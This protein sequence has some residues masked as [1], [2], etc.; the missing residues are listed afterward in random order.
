MASGNDVA[1]MIREIASRELWGACVHE[2][3]HTTVACVLGKFARAHVWRNESG[4]PDEKAWLGQ[5]RCHGDLGE[6]GPVI[7]LAGVVAEIV[8]IDYPK[9]GYSFADAEQEAADIR[10]R[11]P[12]KRWARTR[13]AMTVWCAWVEITITDEK[14]FDMSASDLK[15]M[16]DVWWKHVRKTVRLVMKHTDEILLEAKWLQEKVLREATDTTDDGL[17]AEQL[18]LDFESN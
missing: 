12:T 17:E 16:G 5:T 9:E 10:Q 3:G 6:H 1:S 4:N 8:L 11:Y 2:E 18:H 13:S 15:L 7:A 14:L